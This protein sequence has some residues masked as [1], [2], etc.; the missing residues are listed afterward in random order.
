MGYVRT[1]S[2]PSLV[3]G[4]GLGAS[5][6]YA[7]TDFPSHFFISALKRHETDDS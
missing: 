5:Y 4:I 2:M 1:R 6:A 7:G 3:A